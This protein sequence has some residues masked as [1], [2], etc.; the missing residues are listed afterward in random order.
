MEGALLTK[1]TGAFDGIFELSAHRSTA[2]KLLQVSGKESTGWEAP[3]AA[4]FA[5][6]K[7]SS[8]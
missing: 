7:G 1:A 4:S 5:M 8:V 6:S 3:Q 2:A